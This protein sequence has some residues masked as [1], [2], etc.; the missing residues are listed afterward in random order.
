MS[1]EIQVFDSRLPITKQDLADVSD[2]RKALKE[3]VRT[4]MNEGTDYGIIPGTQ[5]QSLYK[6]G[7]EKLANLFGVGVRIVAK[8]KEIDHHQNFAMFSYTM[9]AYHLRTGTIIGQCEGACNSFEKKY[10]N[11]TVQG[12]KEETPIGDVINTLMK[13]AQKRAYVGVIIQATGASDFYTQDIDD[14][15]DAEALGVKPEPKK[16][17]VAVP[18]VTKAKSADETAA[19]VCCDRPMMISKFHEDTWYCPKCKSSAPMAPQES[20]G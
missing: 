15:Q 9:E 1:N 8:D 20:A 11:R 14:A 17:K 6:P 7:A 2:R 18:S 3:F 4:Q 19:P 16:A 5:K 10:K 12:A 13:M